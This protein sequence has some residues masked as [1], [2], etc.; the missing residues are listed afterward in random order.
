MNKTLKST[1]NK[2][3]PADIRLTPVA[4]AAALDIGVATL[5]RWEK[6]GRICPGTRLSPRKVFWLKSEVDAFVAGS[7]RGGLAS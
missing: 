3:A 7:R 4:V 6:V 5:I 2:T 1:V